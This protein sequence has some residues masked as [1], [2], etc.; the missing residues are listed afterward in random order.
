MEIGQRVGGWAGSY[1]SLAPS[2][3]KLDTAWIECHAVF[4]R[5]FWRH[6]KP[7]RL[8]PLARSKRFFTTPSFLTHK[9]HTYHVFPKT[10][11]ALQ[12]PPKCNRINDIVVILNENNHLIFFSFPTIIYKDL[13]W[14][15]LALPFKSCLWDKIVLFCELSSRS[16]SEIRL[17]AYY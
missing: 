9:S 6:W 17:L 16:P 3:L 15:F 12:N 8:I 10:Y 7:A 14:S 11:H 4:T 13:V 2:N 5:L 1:S